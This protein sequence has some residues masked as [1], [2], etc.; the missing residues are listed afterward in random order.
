MRITHNIT[1]KD[2]VFIN[3]L[4]FLRSLK[5]RFWVWLALGIA[6]GIFLS[7]VSFKKFLIMLQ[8]PEFIMLLI[9]NILPPIM[10]I[11][12][13]ILI[14]SLFYSL[15]FAKKMKGVL[16]QHEVEVGPEGFHERTEMNNSFLKWDCIGKIERFKNYIIF[17][18][19]PTAY[20]IHKRDFS[21]LDKYN[22]FY[23]YSLEQWQNE[24]NLQNNKL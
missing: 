2:I 19:G 7:D 13:V 14:Y 17:Y 15:L 4:I 20:P 5:G 23:E 1:K 10:C 8:K 6:A 11:V 21:D 9:K 3:L 18:I 22:K 16:C 24:K 12:V